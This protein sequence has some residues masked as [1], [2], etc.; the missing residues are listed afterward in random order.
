MLKSPKTFHRLRIAFLK[1]E[2]SGLQNTGT[3]VSFKA[4]RLF[5]GN[6]RALIEATNNFI[7]LAVTAFGVCHFIPFTQ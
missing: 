4:Q 5:V 3:G 2:N 6:L 7:N 1:Q